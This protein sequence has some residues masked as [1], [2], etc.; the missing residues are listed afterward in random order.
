MNT[1]KSVMF[2]TAP[3]IPDQTQSIQEFAHAAPLNHF[4]LKHDEKQ[5]RSQ[6]PYLV[7]QPGIHGFVNVCIEISYRANIYLRTR[8][9]SIYTK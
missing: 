4:Q 5:Q 2:L 1:P 6:Q 8:Q 3:S 9:K 7:S